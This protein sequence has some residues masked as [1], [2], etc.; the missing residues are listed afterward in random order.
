MSQ[1]IKNNHV[2]YIDSKLY[3]KHYYDYMLFRG[4]TVGDCEF[5]LDEKLIADFSTLDISSGMIYSTR[6]WS[7][8]KN[9][10]VELQDIGFTGIDNGFIRYDKDRISNEDFLKNYKNTTIY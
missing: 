2:R 10:G 8:A 6:T 5:D 4:E 7:D 1:N 3:N 9:N